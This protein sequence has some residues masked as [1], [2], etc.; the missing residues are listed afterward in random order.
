MLVELKRVRAWSGSGQVLHNLD[1][2]S[3]RGGK[4]GG[5]AVPHTMGQWPIKPVLR[6]GTYISVQGS[7][8]EISQLAVTH[9]NKEST[10]NVAV[11]QF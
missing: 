4:G 8:T 3:V 5:G 2:G 10:L 7:Q 11:R 9:L 6:L 1:R